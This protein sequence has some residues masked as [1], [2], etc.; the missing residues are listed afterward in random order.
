MCCTS[1]SRRIPENGISGIPLSPWEGSFA[2]TLQEDETHSWG[3]KPRS[4]MLQGY[5][6]SHSKKTPE[7]RTKM[8][9][10][11]VENAPPPPPT[12]KKPPAGSQKCGG[13]V[14]K[15]PPPP[16]PSQ[17]FSQLLDSSLPLLTLWQLHHFLVEG[18]NHLKFAKFKKYFL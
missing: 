2:N 4:Y 15:N 7:E 12:R 10:H 5:L 13:L 3:S 16:P 6:T 9:R 17:G 8:G 1:T 18:T 11:D 14:V